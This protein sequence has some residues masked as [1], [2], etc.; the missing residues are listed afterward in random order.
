M[1]GNNN[2]NNSTI[3][4]NNINND[5]QK[6]KGPVN[7]IKENNN[8]NNVSFKQHMVNKLRDNIF[9]LYCYSF[10]HGLIFTSP[11]LILY[12]KANLSNTTEITGILSMQS[13]TVFLFELP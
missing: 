4:N 1:N 2:P 12:L 8:N 7:E 6:I 13:L 10:T 11:L 5:E 9:L 3:D